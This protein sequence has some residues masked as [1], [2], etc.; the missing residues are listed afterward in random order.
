MSI[1]TEKLEVAKVQQSHNT[2]MEAQRRT[3]DIA[4]THSLLRRWMGASSQRHAPAALY[5]R[6]G[7]CVGLRAGLDT[8]ARVKILSPLRGIEP[9]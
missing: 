4:P 7:R 5:P 8:E 1:R 3:G 9:R 6:T 2:P